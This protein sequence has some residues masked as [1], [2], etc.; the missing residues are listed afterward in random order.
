MFTVCQ[1]MSNDSENLYGF[2]SG[3]LTTTMMQNSQ[4]G[5][6]AY[7]SQS[8]YGNIQKADDID[9]GIW[10]NSYNEG[11]IFTDSAPYRLWN[12]SITL[13]GMSGKSKNSST[14]YYSK[15]IENSKLINNDTIEISYITINDDNTDGD[16]YKNTYYRYYTENGQKASTTRNIYG[17]YDMSGGAFEYVAN[18]LEKNTSSTYVN[19]F[20][21]LDNKYQTSY[22]GSNSGNSSDSI[23]KNYESNSTKYGDALWETSGGCTDQLSWN[24]NSSRFPYFDSS[25]FTRGGYYYNTYDAGLFAF[26]NGYGG[27]NYYGSSFRVVLF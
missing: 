24:R 5:A 16:I 4:W 1:N 3:T 18:Y 26:N 27:N 20:L 15:A 8:K 25:F 2:N 9:S 11:L 22:L 23:T 12:G 10:N 6:I 14:N 21:K 13:T 7:L 19:N 17:I